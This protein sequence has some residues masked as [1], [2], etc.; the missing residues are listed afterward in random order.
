MSGLMTRARCRA[1]A[2]QLPKAIP[3]ALIVVVQ[4]AISLAWQYLLD[5]V[6]EGNFS[7]CYSTE[8]EITEKLY[9][10]LGELDA[11]DDDAIPG[12]SLLQTPVRE[13]NIRSFDGEHLDKQPDLTF[14]PIKGQIPSN[15]SVPTA[16]FIECK[17]VDSTHPVPSTYCRAGLIRFVN[18]DYAW[19]VDRAMMVGYVR[20]ICV[21]PD[22]LAAALA[23][24]ALSSELGSSGKL[25]PLP[26]SGLG[27][28]VCQSTHKRA[29]VLPGTSSA[30]GEIHINHLWLHPEEPCESS[31]CRVV[32]SHSKALSADVSTS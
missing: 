6:R 9:M 16:I 12:L 18:G 26:N 11:A 20:N 3:T 13:G 10:I 28:I 22:G 8:D 7:I 19:A 1:P 14:R 15:N 24:P 30:A 29:F 5:E 23:D 17:P 21:L 32:L 2:D 27:D 25:A 31:R 4:N